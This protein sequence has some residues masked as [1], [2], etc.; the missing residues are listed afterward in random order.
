MKSF[1]LW[2]LGFALGIAATVVAAQ[3]PLAA[4]AELRMDP[5][6]IL[7]AVAQRM[8]VTLRPD[9]P[10]PVIHFESRTPLA[11]FQKAIATQWRFKPP[12]ISNAYVVATNEIYLI[13]DADYYRRVKRSMEDSLAHEF[14]HYLQA[15]YLDADL[16]DDFCETEAIDVQA[17]FRSAF[18]ALAF[19][20]A[21]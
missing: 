4:P 19:E 10:V 1:V 12:V 20:R 8:N 13:D 5:Q 16:K 7:A 6:Q 17:A 9:V 14:A 21:S 3:K 15:L 18:P 2:L 11:Q